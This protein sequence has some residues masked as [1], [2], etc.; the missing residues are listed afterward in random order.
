MK[1]VSL[2]S[3]SGEYT[4]IWSSNEQFLRVGERV[5]FGDP[6]PLGPMG[7]KSRRSQMYARNRR[8]AANMAKQQKRRD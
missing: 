1:P 2:R 4:V 6:P 3:L 5:S 7:R 8:Y